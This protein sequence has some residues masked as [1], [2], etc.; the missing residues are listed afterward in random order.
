MG[1]QY[2]LV[3]SP[4]YLLV[5]LHDFNHLLE[6]MHVIAAKANVAPG[7]LAL[8]SEFGFFDGVRIPV[9]VGCKRREIGLHQRDGVWCCCFRYSVFSC[10]TVLLWNV[11]CGPCQLHNVPIFPQRVHSRTPFADTSSCN[12]ERFYFTTHT[13]CLC[14]RG[15]VNIFSQGLK[16]L[17]FMPSLITPS[18][19]I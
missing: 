15:C 1:E 19:E 2:C 4:Y 16:R 8:R 7:T 10:L 9:T 13:D 14:K 18:E 5:V 6:V 11:E 17:Q 3:L 12:S